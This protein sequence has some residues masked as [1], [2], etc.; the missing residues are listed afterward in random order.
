MSDAVL[1]Y[2]GSAFVETYLYDADRTHAASARPSVATAAPAQAQAHREPTAC[3]ASMSD[4]CGRSRSL[5][6]D[7][8]DA[9]AAT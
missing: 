7:F 6:I 1:R 4:C 9:A 5:S 8:G 3:C 2:V